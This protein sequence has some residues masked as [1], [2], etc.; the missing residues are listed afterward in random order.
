[1]IKTIGYSILVVLCVIST[2]LTCRLYWEYKIP[3]AFFDPDRIIYNYQR[4]LL[5]IRASGRRRSRGR[6]LFRRAAARR[7]GRVSWLRPHRRLSGGGAVR[8]QR[9]RSRVER[10]GGCSYITGQLGEVQPSRRQAFRSGDRLQ[11]HRRVAV[12]QC[13]TRPVSPGLFPRRLVP[14][15]QR[16]S[17]APGDRLFRS[18][19]HPPQDADRCGEASSAGWRQGWS[20]PAQRQQPADAHQELLSHYIQLIVDT[21]RARGEPVALVTFA[22]YSPLSTDEWLKTRAW[23]YPKMIE[24]DV[25]AHNDVL[26]RI[27]SR[28]PNVIPIEMV[29]AIEIEPRLFLR[30]LPSHGQGRPQVGRN[31]PRAIPQEPV[32]Q[33]PAIA[34]P[35]LTAHRS[36]AP[37]IAFPAAG[38]KSRDHEHQT[39]PR[40]RRRPRRLRSRLAGR[41][42]PACRSCCT[43]CG[44][45]AAPT[46]TRPTASPSSSAPTPSAPTTPRPTPSA[47][48]TRRCGC[49]GSLIMR[50]G[51]RASGA[52]R[53]RARRRPRR[54]LRARSR[55]ALEAHPLI[56]IERERGRRPAAAPNGTSVIVATGPLTSPALAEAIAA[57]DRRGRAR[58]LRRHRADRPFRHASTWT[59]PGSSRATTRPGRAAPARTTSTARW[60]RPQ[61]E[62]FVDGAARR[63]QDRVQG[64]GRHALFR[65]L[66]A[67]RGDGRARAARRCATGR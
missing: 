12:Q 33:E 15:D 49:A 10:G 28:A 37:R 61:Y 56:T 13:R 24:Q 6:R 53:R 38:P 58:L 14:A 50:C 30:C 43:R 1:M 55:R 66:P 11:R 59:S 18:A 16:I 57:A 41:R 36:G 20:E 47:C 51:R 21:A 67:D 42:R 4:N 45:C 7:V 40:H 64:M 26:R 19:V 32:V 62:A 44:P 39:H 52:G 65:R 27:G 3:G 31:V 34:A 54:L 23:G 17:R 22:L 8:R 29:G 5:E 63:R 46:R 9:P 2:E 35:I 60:T 25:A 48:C